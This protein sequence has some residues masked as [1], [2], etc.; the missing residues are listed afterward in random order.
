MTEIGRMD[1]L[2]ARCASKS[3]DDVDFAAL[4]IRSMPMTMSFV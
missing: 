4:K 1:S 2:F 3:R